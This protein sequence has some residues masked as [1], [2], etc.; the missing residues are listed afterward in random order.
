MT[1]YLSCYIL[2]HGLNIY[3][4]ILVVY[5]GSLEWCDHWFWKAVNLGNEASSRNLIEFD[6]WGEGW[7]PTHII[8]IYHISFT[9]CIIAAVLIALKANQARS[10]SA[11]EFMGHQEVFAFLLCTAMIIKAFISDWHPQ[12]T[13]WMRVECPQ[14]SKSWENLW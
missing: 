4:Y 10:I 2:P 7:G 11:M 8:Y 14:N 6:I 13:K 3:I 5:I 9:A 1:N 12:I